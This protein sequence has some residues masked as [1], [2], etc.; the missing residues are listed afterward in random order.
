MDKFSQQRLFEIL[1]A[2]AAI[3]GRDAA[4][5]GQSMPNAREAFAHSLACGVFPEVW[6]E[7]PLAG[8][9]WFDLHLLASRESLKSI[10]GFAAEDTGGHPGVFEWFAKEKNVRQLA[11]SWDVGSGYAESPA[12][13]VLVDCDD[14]E[15]SY[16]F[17]RA[18]GRDD[19]QEAYRAFITRK[20]SLWY[21][22][23]TGT[24]PNRK[25]DFVRIECIVNSPQQRMYAR[26]AQLMED[27]LRQAGVRELSETCIAYCQELV[28]SPFQFEFQFDVLPDGTL[29]PTFSASARFACPS[30][31][32]DWPAF[33][34]E[35]AGGVLME[36]VESWG[37]ADE[38]WRLLADTIFAKSAT[39][40]EDKRTLFCYP[41]FVK[42]RFRDGKPLD[43]KAYLLAGIQDRPE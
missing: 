23:Y 28:Q 4:L 34:P 31:Q 2:L 5:F 17:L 3:N 30:E 6:F 12:V 39:K 41:A 36:R 27:D 43:A 13:Q 15:V 37:L 38:R 42:L 11:L 24:F 20:P 10:D 40:G 9:P 7:I 26:D 18:A 8:E 35:G 33:D 32:G 21:A 25:R 14:P 19:L 29:G 22:C 1:Y 16:S